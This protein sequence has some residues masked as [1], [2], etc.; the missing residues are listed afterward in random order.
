MNLTLVAPVIQAGSASRWCES[1]GAWC[2]WWSLA[3]LVEPGVPGGAWCPYTGARWRQEE[4][5][6]WSKGVVQGPEPG[7]REEALEQA[8]EEEEK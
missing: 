2:P 7:D 3:P 5:G 1:G 6:A 8:L 4:A